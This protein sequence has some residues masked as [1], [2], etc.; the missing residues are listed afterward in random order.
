ME[1]FNDIILS[2]IIYI[3]QIEADFNI[4]MRDLKK[5]NL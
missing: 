1:K 3:D 5:R 4:F 2:G